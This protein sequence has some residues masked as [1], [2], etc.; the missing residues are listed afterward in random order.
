[1][2][3]IAKRALVALTMVL[4]IA[5]LVSIAGYR[6]SVADPVVRR[7]TLHLP[8]WPAGA[9]PVT[10]VLIGDVHIGGVTMDGERLTHIVDGVNALRPDIVLL[11]GDFV[12]GHDPVKARR[13][14][15]GLTQPLAR[16]RAPLGVVAVLGNHDHW[17]APDI[18]VSA[19]QRAGVSVLS[20]A[21][22]ERG[23]LAIIGVDD[24]F[25]DH[26]DVARS[27]ASAAALPGVRIVLSHSPNVLP[28]L[29][30][31][32]GTLVLLAHTHCGQVVLPLIGPL[33]E[34]S[35]FTGQWLYDPRYRCGIVRDPHRTIVITGG[36][37]GPPVRLG[38]APDLWLLT[39][40]P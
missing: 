18:V 24:A 30:R 15:A 34:H 21:A 40:G 33:V 14:A 8:H 19:L 39:L 32:T 29:P 35:P 1:M 7:A 11:A 22:I 5:A 6:N 28:M 3:R 16:L 27:R 37:G 31:D 9:A 13:F 36:L 17:T 25:S 4:L 12:A 23:P 38:A 2:N 20:N 26:A 10:A